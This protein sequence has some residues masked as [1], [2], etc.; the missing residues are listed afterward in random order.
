MDAKKIR[1]VV[2]LV[3]NY[4]SENSDSILNE[5]IP[6]AEFGTGSIETIDV[7]LLVES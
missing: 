2:I 6:S 3:G 7:K 1:S 5:L 4:L